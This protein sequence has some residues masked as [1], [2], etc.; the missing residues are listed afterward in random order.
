MIPGELS[1]EEIEA[2][3][4]KERAYLGLP[5][6]DSFSPTFMEQAKYAGTG[7][8][9]YLPPMAATGLPPI[10]SGTDRTFNPT[11]GTS[12]PVFVP[13]ALGSPAGEA[14]PLALTPIPPRPTPS[15]AG[16]AVPQEEIVTAD[17]AQRNLNIP[18][19]DQ[20]RAGVRPPASV[21]A[22]LAQGK[23][24]IDT[25]MMMEREAV[26]TQLAAIEATNVRRQAVEFERQGRMDEAA[27]ARAAAQAADEK[28]LDK[29]E[30]QH[31]ADYQEYK[32]ASNID[33]KR[34][35]ADKSTGDK[36]LASIAVGLGA[37]AQGMGAGPNTALKIMDDAID[38]DM[39]AQEG[40]AREK[41]GVVEASG[42]LLAR[43]MARLHNR[44]LAW[45]KTRLDMMAGYEQKLDNVA[46][47][48]LNDKQKANL[49]AIRAQLM[50]K[51]GAMSQQLAANML[52]S[53]GGGAAGMD[54][55]PSEPEVRERV[56]HGLT[57]RPNEAVLLDSKPAAESLKNSIGAMEAGF[58]PLEQLIKL[59][60]ENGIGAWTPANRAKAEVYHAQTVAAF[61]QMLKQQQATAD[62]AGRDRAAGDAVMGMTMPTNEARA[63][64]REFR[65]NMRSR[66]LEEAISQGGQLVDVRQT[67]SKKTHLRGTVYV[68]QGRML[69]LEGTSPR[70]R[71]A[72]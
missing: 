56:V 70:V 10:I 13:S 61:T 16:G 1:P 40:T 41:R 65:N 4:R 38:R 68:P 27:A 36:M 3:T 72:K 35:W 14:P 48:G 28:I 26:D 58:R 18:I 7:G 45:Q 21:F 39:R 9:P 51:K 60:E 57:R 12:R 8:A 69:G 47:Q 67:M 42:T 15:Q 71:P 59:R 34:F 66:F 20:R 25:G 43:N 55:Q 62:E 19:L 22:Q 6:A 17:E 49:E 44:D 46:Q 32:K 23:R 11:G 54:I 24:D 5:A 50:I 37:F 2:A 64:V 63:V 30:I 53:Y 33:P 31:E 29:I 52:V